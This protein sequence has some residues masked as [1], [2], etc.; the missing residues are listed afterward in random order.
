MLRQDFKC[1]QKFQDI[2]PE[3]AACPVK[4]QLWACGENQEQPQTQMF[5]FLFLSPKPPKL[6]KRIFLWHKYLLQNC[7]VA[8]GIKWYIQAVHF[9]LIL[10]KWASLPIPVHI[11]ALDP[12]VMGRRWEAFPVLHGLSCSGGL[13]DTGDYPSLSITLGW[14][15][16][17]HRSSVPGWAEMLEPIGQE[18]TG[19]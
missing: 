8:A 19:G 15:V 10:W 11:S 6:V 17:G 2:C 7:A 14:S 5:L 1:W 13:W 9:V 12:V 3:L 16:R 4:I 18:C